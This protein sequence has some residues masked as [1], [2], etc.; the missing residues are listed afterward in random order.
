MP[1]SVE[2]LGCDFLCCSGHKMLGPTGT[3]VLWM[4][5]PVLEPM[6][7]GGGSVEAMEGDEFVF[8]QGYQKYEAGTPNISG[9]IGLGA[10]VDYLRA[11]GME[12]IRE[13]DRRLT[14]RIIDGLSK[15]EGVSVYA[16]RD[17]D[18][19]IGV[20]SFTVR[21]FDP[22]AVA[23]HLDENAD[24][25]VRSGHHCCIPLMR[26]LGLENGSVR[27]SLHIYNTE[28]DVDHLIASVS[29]IARGG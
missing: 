11:I 2:Q 4:R 23:H 20:V 18:L 27:A 15:I 9:G 29:E 28:S 24:I 21:G 5:E 8:S 12:T 25:M 26:R 1:V 13:H 7:V 6:L 10:A 22:H 16:Q 14:A 3:G 17:P 19:R